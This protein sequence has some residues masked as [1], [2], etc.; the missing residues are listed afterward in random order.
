[1]L[2]LGDVLEAAQRT[3][4]ASL[5]ADTPLME[6]GVDSLGA[7]ELRNQL[8]HLGGEA[9]P[10]TVVFDHPTARQLT[11]LFSSADAR[12]SNEPEQLQP[13]ACVDKEPPPTGVQLLGLSALHPNGG[14]H[15]GTCLDSVSEVPTTRWD[16]DSLET[17]GVSTNSAVRH[18]G[19]IRGA[20]L[21]DNAV[22]CISSA[23]ATAMERHALRPALRPALRHA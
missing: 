10:P 7:V 16:L 15:T 21:V 11:A 22:F 5:D 20:Q 12:K 23:E 18:G 1:M 2:L 19:F 6:A 14:E 8:Q 3:A 13:R 17:C 4:G 9:L